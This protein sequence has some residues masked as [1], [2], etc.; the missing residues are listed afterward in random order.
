MGTT[1]KIS[2]A[3]A[4]VNFWHGCIKVSEGC[5]YCYMYRDKE[6]HKQ[7][8]L[9]IVKRD[10]N[11]I[12]RELNKAIKDGVLFPGARVFTCSWS[13]FW[14]AEADEWRAEAIELIREYSQFNWLVLTKRPERMNLKLPDNVWL[15]VSVENCKNT[16]RIDILKK[17]AKEYDFKGIL[18]ISAE[19]L[20]GSMNLIKQLV[21]RVGDGE[22]FDTPY[23]RTDIH[24]VIIGGESGNDR[25][26]YRYRECFLHWIESLVM[27]CK[28]YEVPVFVKQSGTHIAK[29]YG[30]K[31]RHGGNME[32]WPEWMKVRE[33]PSGEMVKGEIV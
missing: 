2:W 10:F 32:E 31:D 14:L 15:G 16:E 21:T 25:G 11:V 29:E 33:F 8:P 12:R 19:P 28:Q 17:Y 20:I 30:Y 13:D 23:Y 5:K 1:T 7:D 26:K 3:N 6:M 24:W 9:K 22:G 18:F 4:T 27:Q